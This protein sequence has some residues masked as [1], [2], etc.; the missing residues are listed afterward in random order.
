MPPNIKNLLKGL[1]LN[2]KTLSSTSNLRV[3]TTRLQKQLDPTVMLFM[4]QNTGWSEVQIG[5]VGQESAL[6]IVPNRIP[7]S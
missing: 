5:E 1:T 6:N 7:R 2:N 3:E 4:M